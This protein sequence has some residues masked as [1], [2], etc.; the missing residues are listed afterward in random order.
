MSLLLD[1]AYAGLSLA[2]SA[3]SS[4]SS[5]YQHGSQASHNVEQRGLQEEA[6]R[7][8][9]ERRQAAEEEQVQISVEYAPS[10]ESFV[11]GERHVTP[12]SPQG[13]AAPLRRHLRSHIHTHTG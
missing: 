8:A 9:A 6:E 13:D 5:T 1:A 4:S 12:P 2:P 3:P 10:G 7:L 11:W